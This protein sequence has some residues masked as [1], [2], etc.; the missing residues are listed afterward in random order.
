MCSAVFTWT[1][2]LVVVCEL[3]GPE[4]EAL[5]LVISATNAI[6]EEH[7][8]IAGIVAVVDPGTVP[9]NSKGEKQR[10]HLRDSFLADK[11][12]PIYVAYNM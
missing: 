5:N 1:N 11:L 2:L 7:H 6:I 3:D 12:D 10:M 4:N 9:I 8:L